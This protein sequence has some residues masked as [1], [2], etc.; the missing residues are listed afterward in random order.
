MKKPGEKD[1]SSPLLYTALSSKRDKSL[2]TRSLVPRD[3]DFKKEM[4]GKNKL[5]LASRAPP[6][7]LLQVYNKL[8]STR[9]DGGKRSTSKYVCKNMKKEHTKIG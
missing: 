9:S 2:M 4:K 1:S 7:V 5:K 6:A 3:N 8:Y